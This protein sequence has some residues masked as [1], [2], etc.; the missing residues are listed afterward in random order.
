MAEDTVFIDAET[1]YSGGNYKDK[2]QFRDI[3]LSFVQQIGRNANCEFRGGYW[4]EKPHPNPNF[5]GV[6]KIYIP[7]SREVYS[8]SVEYLY[9]ILY[10]HF[11]KKTLEILEKIEKEKAEL[12]EYKD[13][14][15]KIEYRTQRQRLNRKLFREICSFLQRENY[16]EISGIIDY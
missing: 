9:D 14:Q 15:E 5:N 3:V 4:E 6:I 12:K 1:H 7:D 10:P 16:F 8:N 13:D 2:I 11:D